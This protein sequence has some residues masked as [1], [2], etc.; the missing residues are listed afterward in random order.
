MINEVRCRNCN[1]IIDLS[2]RDEEI[3]KEGEKEILED[4]NKIFK[5]DS[6]YT[7]RVVKFEIKNRLAGK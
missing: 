7:G 2:E 6:I 3:E 5:D 1:S 4:I